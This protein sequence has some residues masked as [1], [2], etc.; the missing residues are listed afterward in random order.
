MR[1]VM[2]LLLALV[3]CATAC[4]PQG[5][6]SGTTAIFTAGSTTDRTADTATTTSTTVTTTSTAKTAAPRATTT[7]VAATT[8]T[9]TAVMTTTTT[10][11]SYLTDTDD[12]LLTDPAAPTVGIFGSK[13]ILSAVIGDTL[14][15]LCAENGKTLSLTVEG[16][17]YYTADL[18]MDDRDFVQSLR[19]GAYDVVLL[20]GVNS[21]AAVTAIAA[22]EEACLQGGTVP[23]LLP[24]PDDVRSRVIAAAEAGE[25][26]R[27]VDW[28]G[29]EQ[30]LEEQGVLDTC[31]DSRYTAGYAAAVLVYYRLYGELPATGTGTV[32]ALNDLTGAGTLSPEQAEALL[33]TLR[34]LTG[35]FSGA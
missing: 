10:A 20:S 6:P 31:P 11:F 29:L 23:V 22:F 19:D 18:Y 5:T 14:T 13:T 2:L 25:T 24:A 35:Q 3:C 1:R 9:I 21:K 15:K 27:V 34:R 30:Y 16:R 26:L 17:D 33:E 8:T 28:Q 7:M 32:F 12:P 4:Y